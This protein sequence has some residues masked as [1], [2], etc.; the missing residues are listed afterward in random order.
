MYHQRRELGPDEAKW[1]HRIMGGHRVVRVEADTKE[2]LR[3]FVEPDENSTN[4]ISNGNS[5]GMEELD[6]DLI[7]S[8]TG[9]Q[10][11]AHVAMLKGLWPL[12][13]KTASGHIAQDPGAGIG[14]WVVEDTTSPEGPATKL[15]SV[16]RDYQVGF[17]PGRVAPGSGIWLQG[18]CE[19]THGVS[20][21]VPADASS[22]CFAADMY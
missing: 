7:I 19:G 18:C 2:H 22:M 4:G 8:A 1:P 3:L 12:L 20:N 16:A 17:A 14:N 5:I 6:V 13:P 10:R 15:L 9:Y 21:R 11:N